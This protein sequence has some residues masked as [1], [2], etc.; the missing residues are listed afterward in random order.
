MELNS[1]RRAVIL[2]STG[3]AEQGHDEA[4]NKGFESSTVQAGSWHVL[5]TQELLAGRVEESRLNG[6][7]QQQVCITLAPLFTSNIM[8]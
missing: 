7:Q 6:G 5:V 2:I 1:S 4:G 3:S 8:K